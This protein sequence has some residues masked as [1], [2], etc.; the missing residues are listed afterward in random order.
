MNKTQEKAL[1]K[2]MITIYCRGKHKSGNICSECNSL[3]EYAENRLDKCPMGDQRTTCQNCT[4]HCYS[5]NMKEKIR[6]VMRYSGKR[7][8]LYHP[9]S[10][11]RHL[12]QLVKR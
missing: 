8:I 5:S 12:M 7:I 1:L 10:A 6:D 2:S 4:I 9:L 3:L 11:I